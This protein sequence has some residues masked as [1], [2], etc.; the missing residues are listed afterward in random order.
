MGRK[1]HIN[2]FFLTF[3]FLLKERKKEKVPEWLLPNWA[4]RFFKIKRTCNEKKKKEKVHAFQ[5]LNS[6][7]KG[8]RIEHVSN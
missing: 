6:R 1:K 7:E 8:R 5:T 4:N 3:S 2:F